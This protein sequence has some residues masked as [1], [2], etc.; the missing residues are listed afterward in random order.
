VTGMRCPNLF[1]LVVPVPFALGA[2][3]EECVTPDFALAGKTW[4][5]FNTVLVHTPAELDPAFPGESSPANGAHDLEIA[6]NT[7][8]LES[9]VTVTLDGQEFPGQGRWSDT[10]CGAFSVTFEGEYLSEDGRATHNFQAAAAL[11]TWPGH[12]EGVWTYAEVWEVR[13]LSGRVDFDV[14]MVGTL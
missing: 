1:V 4:A 7:T 11:Q 14:Q 2:C 10:A 3:A 8:A 5:V 13:D 6:W 12:L 9:P